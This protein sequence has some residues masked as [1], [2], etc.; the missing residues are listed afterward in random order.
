[1]TCTR[2]PDAAQWQLREYRRRQRL[3]QRELADRLG[4]APNTVARWE[5]GVL[6]VPAVLLALMRRKPRIAKPP[7][8]FHWMVALGGLRVAVES[9]VESWPTHVRQVVPMALRDLADI[10]EKEWGISAGQPDVSGV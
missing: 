6:P 3:T 2:Y 1:M 5:R 8:P 7:E 4:V 10:L 9:I